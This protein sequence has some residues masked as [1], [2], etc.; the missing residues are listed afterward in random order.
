MEFYAAFK[1][2]I[3][4]SILYVKATLRS[5]THDV[6]SVQLWLQ[7]AQTQRN[8]NQLLC[9]PISLFGLFH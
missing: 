9:W 1:S 2:H 8:Y 6:N 7:T 5:Y 3:Y 4:D